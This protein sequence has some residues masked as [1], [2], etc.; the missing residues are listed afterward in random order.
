M[1]D[2]IFQ[3]LKQAYPHLGLADDILEAHSEGLA[4]LG[5]VDDGNLDDVIAKQRTFLESLQKHNDRRVT[6]ALAKAQKE[7]EEKA[8][9]A[10]EE[11]ARAKEEKEKKDAGEAAVKAQEIPGPVKDL[12]ESV[13][14]EL[15]KVRSEAEEARKASEAAWQKKLDDMAGIVTGLQ[16]EN[17]E[18]K[19]AE[20]VR[21]RAERIEARAK[22]LGIPE[23]RIREGFS[24]PDGA[25][26][27]AIGAYLSKVAENIKAN[28]V[29]SRGGF[30][31]AAGEPDDG[32]VGEIAEALVGNL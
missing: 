17:D 14:A 22:E 26:D 6:D 20:A 13:Q 24:I 18:A 21:L 4:Q 27:G 2:K 5:F 32:E 1:K 12:I 23:F 8:R 16:K 28:L 29:P 10:G 15:G 9:R 19:K 31:I 25:D 3:R 30:P 7:A 11:A